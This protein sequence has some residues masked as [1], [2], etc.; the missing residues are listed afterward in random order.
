MAP[1]RKNKKLASNPARGFATTSIA[2]KANDVSEEVT[3]KPS[4][5]DG[6]ESQTVAQ[7]V[8]GNQPPA[9][10]KVH[11]LSPEALE[12]H[13][14]ESELQ[15][16]VEKHI[17]KIKRDA[18]RQVAKLQTDKRLLRVQAEPLSTRSWLPPEVMELI[19][20]TLEAEKTLGR[21]GNGTQ[22]EYNSFEMS[23]DDLCIRIWTL[24]QTLIQLGFAHHNCQGALQDLL[25]VCQRPSVRDSL[26]IK[27]SI[28][29]LDYCLDWLAFHYEAREVPPYNSIHAVPKVTPFLEQ[30]HRNNTS[31]GCAGN[32]ILRTPLASRSPSP[33]S[34][35]RTVDN[36][37]DRSPEDAATTALD[38]TESENDPENMTETYV[39]LQ[40]Q[41]YELQP[42]L[43]NSSKNCKIPLRHGSAK[44]LTPEIIKIH[45]R[46][47]RLK[48]D[49]LFDLHEAEERWSEKHKQLMK[50]AAERRKLDLNSESRPISYQ[51]DGQDTAG[52][53]TVQA[54][55]TS[56]GSGDDSDLEALGEFFSGLPDATTS[57]GIN[58]IDSDTNANNPLGRP[59]I[60][61]NFGKWNGVNPRRTFE[62]ACKARD[63]SARITFQLIDR[64]PFSK[65][66]SLNIC[67]SSTQPQPLDS[68]TEA[69]LCESDQRNVRIKMLTEAVPNA[70]QSEA[71]VAT[72]ALFLIFSAVPKEEKAS[73][74]L[75]PAWKDF[76]LELSSLKKGND[77][78]ADCEELR[79]IRTLVDSCDWKEEVLA[80]DP[81]ITKSR[82]THV[83]LENVS[84]QKKDTAGPETTDHG[85]YLKSIWSSKSAAPSFRSML[86]QR[87]SLPIWNFKDNILQNIHGHQIVIV[88]GETGCGKSTQV[89][90]FI[91]EH[92]L[93]SGR[94]CKIY[95]TEPRRISAISLARRVS[96][97]L[98]ERK[99]DIGTP[100]SLVG[101]A[102]RLESKMVRETKLVYATT[103][104]VLR[105]LEASDNLH[106]I[107]HLILDEV[108]ERSIESDFLLIVLRKLLIRRPALKVIL[109]SATVD[110]AKFSSYFNGAPVLTVPG[111]TFPVQIQYL[112]DAI[113]ET[114]F[115]NRDS[116]KAVP[117]I[118]DDEEIQVSSSPTD[119]KEADTGLDGYS[120]KTQSTLARLDEYRINYDLIVSL[121]ETI[122]TKPKFTGFNK[123][124]L[125]F[126]PGIAEIRRLKDM[127][128][129]QAAF[130]H[131][132]NIH[133]LHSTIAMDEQERAFVIP[134]PG[135][136]KIV[137]A[138]NIAE[139]GVTI[140]DVTCVID[141]GKHKEMR[142]D[143]RRQLSRLIEI[144][145]S[146][147]NAK[148]RRGRAGRVQEGICFHLFTK[149]RY[150]NNMAQDQT[151]EILR[152][153][154]QD[155]VLRVKI[156]KLGSIEQTLAEALD[157]PLAKN[158]RR[159]ID[160][161]VDVKALTLSEELTPLG[162]QLAKIPLDVFLG[163]LILLGCIF[164][165][166][167]GALTIAAIL[168]S[169]PPFSAPMGA[170]SQAEQARL[171]FKRGEA[172]MDIIKPHG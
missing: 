19:M 152:L 120:Q 39:A 78:A 18:S 166:L 102:I 4:P 2:S 112:E 128:S 70:A 44:A 57:V 105:M 64:S 52:R 38:D 131:G 135:H 108:H 40:T 153:S 170:R 5:P 33:H 67:W 63:S 103:G 164:K 58:R 49:I 20:Q 56:N 79:G 114:N 93:S 80:Q 45:Q 97:E 11:E 71:Y 3:E 148:Q 29:G 43:Q 165:C 137:L 163:K 98:G 60:I 94:G 51:S 107:T 127:L 96:E 133:P 23:E 130:I 154:L 26:M 48:A 12:K 101:Y 74:R 111:R 151:P 88:C 41:L 31:N 6:V 61:R 158:I 142:F 129:G 125:V 9:E 85:D 144:F 21:P 118:D 116:L 143:E 136:C 7:M 132:W 82:T 150:E 145:I 50:A 91:L 14:E 46:L 83:G 161:L 168:S 81:G 95:C 73:L 172:I 42:D 66:H 167:D 68:P 140:P 59:V 28:W 86:S 54:N 134:P 162:R 169:K 89:P 15:L 106:E 159:A 115:S 90:S 92:E 75:P 100:R 109:M 16:F 119:K 104:I 76:W 10:Q 147:A 160:A 157:P 37:G 36:D 65:Q 62:E 87:E 121:L 69:I 25:M 149:S 22:N 27:D 124:I 99:S 24:K 122:A 146:R 8:C 171:A 141:V 35:K 32:E 13:L 110:A 72:A 113:E 138:T 17:S 34:Q 77:M 123:A 139:T 155:L 156:C 47:E 1:K 55:V 126:L 30:H 84:A 117:S 53:T